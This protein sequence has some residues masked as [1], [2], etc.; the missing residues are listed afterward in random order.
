MSSTEK[1]FS[2]EKAVDG[3]LGPNP[4]RCNCCSETIYS[5][6]SWWSV[7]LGQRYPIQ[8]VQIYGRSDGMCFY[9]SGNCII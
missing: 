6:I 4:E 8:S 3:L 1:S 2:S 5:E 7:D 9:K